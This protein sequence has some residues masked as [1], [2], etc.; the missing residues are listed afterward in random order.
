MGFDI[1]YNTTFDYNIRLHSCINCIP[2]DIPRIVWHYK[3]K[4]NNDNS[5]HVFRQI[6][7]LQ[8]GFHRSSEK[9]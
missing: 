2:T 1:S 7:V 9:K 6:R 4:G 3:H 5:L 8:T